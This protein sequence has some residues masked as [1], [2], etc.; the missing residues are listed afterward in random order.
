MHVQILPYANSS[1]H[2]ATQINWQST[3]NM[4]FKKCISLYMINMLSMKHLRRTKFA[5]WKQ[6][7]LQTSELISM[8]HLFFW[9][10]SHYYAHLVFLPLKHAADKK[11]LQFTVFK[12]RCTQSSL[13]Y[14]ARFPTLQVSIQHFWNKIQ[15]K[16]CSLKL[17]LS[18]SP[19]YSA[20]AMASGAISLHYTHSSDETC[21]CVCVCVYEGLTL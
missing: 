21:M 9:W 3:L 19:F 12:F 18:F 11:P 17:T 5:L 20:L 14:D 6:S 7:E 8:K 15:P 1:S 13:W 16:E 2:F 4:W 10:P